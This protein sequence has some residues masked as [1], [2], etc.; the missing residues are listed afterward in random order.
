MRL[1]TIV[2]T[3]IA[4]A[5]EIAMNGQTLSAGTG[6]GGSVTGTAAP[7]KLQLWSAAVPA[8][9]TDARTGTMLLE[10]TLPADYFT[11]AANGV[12]SKNGT[13]SGNGL[14]AAAGGT[15]ALSYCIVSNDG[16]TVHEDGPVSL[17]VDGNWAGG[18]LYNTVGARYQNGGNIYAVSAAGTSAASGGPTGTGASIVDGTVTWSYVSSYGDLRLNNLSIASGQLV[19]VDSKTLTAGNA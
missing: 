14:P 8:A 17:T 6:T 5:I 3:A 9:I 4:E 11:A 2:R 1:G 19:T 13:W 15:N 16:T 18:T 10:I 7:P 12:K